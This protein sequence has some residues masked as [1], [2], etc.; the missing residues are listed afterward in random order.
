MML[1]VLP[2]NNIQLH[3]LVNPAQ[4][5]YLEQGALLGHVTHASG[6]LTTKTLPSR[7]AAEYPPE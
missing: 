3:Y 5:N 1:N 6:V 2:E 4:K 7:V